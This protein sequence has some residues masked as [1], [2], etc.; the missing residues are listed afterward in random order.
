MGQLVVYPTI[1]ACF[2]HNDVSGTKT[3]HEIVLGAGTEFDDDGHSEYILLW[4]SSAPDTNKWRQVRRIGLVFNTAALPN[5][6]TITGATLKPRGWAKSNGLVCSPNVCLY[7]FSPVSEAVLAITDYALFG[8]DALSNIID[9]ASWPIDKSQVT[10]TLNPA[11]LAL[12]NKTGNTCLGLRNANYD[13]ADLDPAWVS[14]QSSALDTYGREGESGDPT[15]GPLLTIDYT[16]AP[17]VLSATPNS[18]K[19]GE[20]KDIVLAGTLLTGATAVDFGALIT[21]DHFHVDSDNQVTANIILGSG[22]TLGARDVSIT[23]PGGV[24]VLTAGFMVDPATIS[25]PGD[26][27]Y[28]ARRMARLGF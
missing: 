10:F 24:G 8:H 28:F 4:A 6:C 20:T 23:T 9:Y 5:G 27:A 14:N 11:G 21:V 15:E 12:I 3:F 19:R 22:A 18:A 2:T 1:D 16:E 7:Q 26:G 25:G 17:T 13:V